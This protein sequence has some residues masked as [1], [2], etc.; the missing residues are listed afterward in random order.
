M[1]ELYRKIVDEKT[2]KEL[3]FKLSFEEVMKIALEYLLEEL[4]KKKEYNDYD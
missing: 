2:G 3:Y 1:E 4:A